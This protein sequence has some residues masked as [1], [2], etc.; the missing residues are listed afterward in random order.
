MQGEGVWGG[1]RECARAGA[2]WQ[3]PSASNSL[4]REFEGNFAVPFEGI[5]K[6]TILG[7]RRVMEP[8][9]TRRV[10][11]ILQPFLSVTENGCAFPSKEFEEE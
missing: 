6:G 10:G 11:H 1:V 5:S 4:P 3:G 2:R 9:C 7:T 8:S